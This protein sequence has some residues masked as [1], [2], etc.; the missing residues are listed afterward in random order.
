MKT[1]LSQSVIQ[2]K[3]N[4]EKDW[5]IQMI[6][7]HAD[8]INNNDKYW[9]F[10]LDAL[11]DDIWIWCILENKVFCSNQWKE[12][13]GYHNNEMGDSFQ[14]W[15]SLVH[16]DDLLGYCNN[17]RRHING[18][19]PMFISDHR[20]R[21]SDGSYRWFRDNGRVISRT[22]NGKPLLIIG[23]H[24]DITESKFDKDILT[25][26]QEKPKTII[27]IDAGLTMNL[28][29]LIFDWNRQAEKVFSGET[30]RA[31]ER[32]YPET[33]QRYQYHETYVEESKQCLLFGEDA[34]LYAY[35]GNP[36]LQ[37]D[38]QESLI[39]WAI[40]PNDKNKQYEF[41]TFNFDSSEAR[42]FK[43]S[44][45]YSVSASVSR[46]EASMN[47]EQSHRI[48]S[49]N[50]MKPRRTEYTKNTPTE[51]LNYR[52][53]QDFLQREI[54]K[55]QRANC[56]LAVLLVDFSNF[57]FI[58]DSFEHESSESLLVEIEKQISRCVRES[59]TVMRV[60]G[61]Q[62][63][64]I[65]GQLNDRVCVDRVARAIIDTLTRPFQF[66]NETLY[67]VASIGVSI[68]P[69]DATG[70]SDLVINAGQALYSSKKQGGNCFNHFSL[71]MLEDL[72]TRMSLTHE[73][74]DALAGHQFKLYYQPIVELVTGTTHKAEALIRWQHPTRGLMS[75]ADFISIAEESGMM[76]DIGDWVFHTAAHQVL[77]WH[78]AYHEHFQVI[79]NMSS[80]QLHSKGE[81][82]ST[83]IDYLRKINLSGESIALEI[84]EEG[85]L[86]KDKAVI[87]QLR[88]FRN[89]N[90]RILL[91]DF[92]TGFL[93]L[94]Y[95][96][97]FD[98]NYIKIDRSF[99]HSLALNAHDRAICEAIISMAHK[100]GMKVIAEGVE[101]NDQYNLLIDAG[102]D[103]GQGFL[104]SGP[105]TAVNFN[106]AIG[107]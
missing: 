63:A 59:D 15:R 40:A 54:N 23:V 88:E 78:R 81:L 87:N 100:L 62:F 94:P 34:Q 106:T 70:I 103:Y 5:K 76:Q 90:I 9:M 43:A 83:W 104:F 56:L 10:T 19:I 79:I 101:T 48:M 57:K 39:E 44:P 36:T 91:D 32:K 11:D 21:C 24:T 45:K 6:I 77:D 16:P 22:E 85:L 96:K 95:L 26:Q 80:I 53:F 75:P 55:T 51:M 31:Y 42:E 69:N 12:M 82:S 89:A 68:Y 65:M 49:V 25:N 52:H 3:I 66:D 14:D 18:D 47:S 1:K 105:V 60:D 61:D 102:C 4:D 28:S 99:V 20:M 72:Q 93:S 7:S 8:A 50:S 38:G 29:E 41:G 71:S 86:K 27:G 98:I 13:L 73:L 33:F 35:A 58:N 84:S 2:P 67:L 30:M 92:G 97:K 17:F 64:V 107:L 46:N 37:R 74:Q